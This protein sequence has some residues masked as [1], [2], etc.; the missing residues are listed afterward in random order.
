[1][2][3]NL[4]ITS[5]DGPDLDGTASAIAYS[6]LLCEN[7]QFAMPILTGQPHPEV[8]YILERLHIDYP[9]G[10]I[11]SESKI[12]LV[13]TSDLPGLSRSIN[14]EK[15]VEI[16]D[17]RKVSD[18]NAF[19]NAKKQIELVGAAATL[20]TEKF[21][22][23]KIKPT[24][25]SA[26]LLYRGM[27][28]NTLNFQSASTTKRDLDMANW[29][30]NIA[31]IP[32]DLA[33]EMFDAKTKAILQNLE[34]N[35]EDDLKIQ[36]CDNTSVGIAQLELA[37]SAT[38]LSCLAQINSALLTIKRKLSLDDI[39]LTVVDINEKFNLIIA[40]E[41]KIH[42]VLEKSL[43]ITFKDGYAVRPG[44]ILQKEIIPLIKELY[45]RS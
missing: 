42:S 16:I 36:N 10:N 31:E 3:E 43:H 9:T 26:I 28:S 33:K 4:I 34:K 41:E 5:Y 27:I 40:P 1:M 38:I 23:Q 29:L 7:G 2:K 8:K 11:D 14:P 30:S 17:H 37:S 19:K 12:I 13:D 45:D 22:D 6:E 24:E 35:L 15:V 39:F 20:I 25:I 21:Y 44:L 32:T 18:E